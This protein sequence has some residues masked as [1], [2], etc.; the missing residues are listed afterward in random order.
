M[1]LIEQ[2]KAEMNDLFEKEYI[3]LDVDNDIVMASN[4]ID[5]TLKIVKK[6]TELPKISVYDLIMWHI[7][8]RG[9]FVDNLTE[10][11]EKH[12]KY[13]DFIHSYEQTA[14]LMGI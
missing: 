7:E 11:V 6:Y 3:Y 14:L 1:S 4:S 5:D 9:K 12:F 13:E 10:D 8:S 2:K